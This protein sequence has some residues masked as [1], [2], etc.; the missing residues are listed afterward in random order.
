MTAPIFT[1]RKLTFTTTRVAAV[2]LGAMTLLTSSLSFAD[3]TTVKRGEYLTRGFGC[4][5]CH[6]PLIMGANGP[7]PDMAH[8]LSGHPANM[9]VTP[10]AVPKGGWAWMGAASNTAFQ[11][12]WGISYAVNLTPDA[13][14]GLGKWSETQFVSALKTGKHVGV[15][16]PILP[17]MP[18][19]A[20][21]TLTDS[22][23]KA[24]FAY[25][26]SVPA[27]SNRVPDPTPPVVQTAA[28]AN[29]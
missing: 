20:L 16:R 19:Q 9:K 24:I 7:E 26:R 14:T 25:L 5:D 21:S 11:G 18:W 29:H 10:V 13:E 17:P 12:P 8:H 28:T 3:P 1:A 4:A 6:T 22:D 23:L 15:S 2:A 27:V